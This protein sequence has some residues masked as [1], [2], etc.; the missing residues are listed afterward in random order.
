[1]VQSCILLKFYIKPQLLGCSSCFTYVVSYWN[2]TSNHNFGWQRE[3]LFKVVSYWNS[4]SNHNV[5]V[6][7][8]LAKVLY[9]IEILHQTTTTEGAALAQQGC[10][11]LKF[12][13]K[14]QLLVQLNSGLHGCILL[15]FY[16]KPQLNCR[17]LFPTRVVSYWNSTSNH[18]RECRAFHWGCVVSYWNST[19]NHNCCPASLCWV[20][21]YLIEILHQTTTVLNDYYK[22]HGCILL[23]FYIKPQLTSSI[24]FLLVSC[25]L[26][27]FYIKPQLLS[28][29]YMARAVVSYWNSTSNH[30][31]TSERKRC[32]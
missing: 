31:Q 26:L 13:I 17:S 30:N 8:D 9:L 12:Y 21:L 3:H 27:K 6:S 24:G 5:P 20:S 25:I 23:K 32:P 1:M 19:S 10:I 15:K 18:N 22:N 7:G 2:S 28:L 16:I 14:P 4:T 11:L 29:S